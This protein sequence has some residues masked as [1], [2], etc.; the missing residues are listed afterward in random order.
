MTNFEK[1]I[2]PL[3]DSNIETID[4]NEESGFV[5]SYTYDPDSPH[6]THCLFLMYDM[7][8]N[9]E[10]SVKRY[11]KFDYNRSIKGRYVKIINKKH[12]LVYKFW[13]NPTI[14]KFYDYPVISLNKDQKLKVL[15]F[16]GADD[17]II[18]IILSNESLINVIK[19]ETPLNDYIPPYWLQRKN[20]IEKERSG[21]TIKKGNLD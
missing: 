16:Y 18:D 17:P 13:L 2:I 14:R 20:K 19:H 12:Y 9:N 10:H 6:E 3:L 5:D 15:Q 7:D 8:V 21:L 1:I 4:L 11:N